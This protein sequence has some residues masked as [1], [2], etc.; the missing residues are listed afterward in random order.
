MWSLF[1]PHHGE[2]YL[3]G[4]FRNKP[5]QTKMRLL[6]WEKS[7]RCDLYRCDHSGRLFGSVA[8]G[9][10]I[11]TS[12]PRS[13]D[14]GP[15]EM[16]WAGEGLLKKKISK[17][18]SPL[19]RWSPWSPGPLVPL[20]RWSPHPLVLW[21][22]GPLVRWSP[23]W[24]VGPLVVVWSFA[25]L[26]RCALVVWSPG[27]LLPWSVRW[28]FGLL[29]RW[30]SSPLVSLLS[31][32]CPK[33]IVGGQQGC[34]SFFRCLGPSLSKKNALEGRRCP[35][36]PNPPPAVFHHH[37]TACIFGPSDP[38]M[39]LYRL[40]LSSSADLTSLCLSLY[41]MFVCRTCI[42]TKRHGGYFSNIYYSLYIFLYFSLQLSLYP[43]RI[44]FISLYKSLYYSLHLYISL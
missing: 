9:H 38:T 40:Y 22:A 26:V 33:W 3:A 19:V 37:I 41:N 35:L 5:K 36:P 10:L 31:H 8:S 32:V 42:L 43:F 39:S 24:S 21:S 15:L 25:S 18:K 23:V 6:R 12:G 44:L 28:S 20:V 16:G 30:Y 4:T 34:S 11:L 13:S 17:K 1:L 27:P 2:K 7:L 14:V 29:V